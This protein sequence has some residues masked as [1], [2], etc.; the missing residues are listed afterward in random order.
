MFFKTGLFLFGLIPASLVA[1]IED[2]VY[3]EKI[4]NATENKNASNIPGH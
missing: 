1:Q 2:S 3:A 4:D